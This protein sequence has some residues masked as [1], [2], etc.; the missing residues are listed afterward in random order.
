MCGAKMNGSAGAVADRRHQRGL[1]EVRGRPDRDHEDPAGPQPGVE[2]RQA[3][4]VRR[5]RE[6]REHGERVGEV[7]RL[8]ERQ[9]LGEEVA[10]GQRRRHAVLA[11]HVEDRGDRI[12]AVE[13]LG[14]HVA[15]EEAREPAP[16]AA[17]VEHPRV[18]E[19]PRAG[20]R[21]AL[22]EQAVEAGALRGE[23][24][25]PRARSSA[26]GAPAR[27]RSGSGARM[28]G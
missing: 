25:R 20:L 15:G 10:L 11:A 5:L 6:V 27:A 28:S 26:A 18:G 8:V 14:R 1:V 9:P 13:A 7:E 12:A 2:R 23:R 17:E 21:V 3:A 4:L 24:R 19:R 16:A 22:A